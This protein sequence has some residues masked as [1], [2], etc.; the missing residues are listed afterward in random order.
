MAKR[1]T[2]YQGTELKLN[3]NIEPVGTLSM[4]EYE[5]ACTAFCSATKKVVATKAECIEVDKDNYLFL[6]DTNLTGCGDLYVK[7][8]AYLPDDSFVKS[9]NLRTE[10]KIVDTGLTVVS[11]YTR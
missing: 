6:V 9:D 7:V 10:V 1:I 4:E 5:F 11:K 8:E 2:I 3:V